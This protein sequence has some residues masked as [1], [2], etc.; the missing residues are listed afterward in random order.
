M[1]LPSYP[2]ACLT[3]GIS[4]S[5][6]GSGIQADI[7][8]FTALS[9]HGASVVVAVAAQSLDNRHDLHLVPTASVC[10]QLD[11]A[12]EDLPVGCVKVGLIPSLDTMR[13]VARW[14][15]EHPHLKVVV[16]PVSA[17][18]RGLPLHSPEQ[19]AVLKDELLP[20]ATVATPNRQEAALLAGLEEVLSREDME[21][22]AKTILSKHGCPTLVTGGGL[23][24]QSLDVLA[25]MDGLRHFAFPTVGRRK[26]HGAGGTLSAA[27]A[28]NLAKGDSVREAVLAGKLYVSAALQ[29][30][31]V[32]P[33]GR[34]VLWHP[35]TVREGVIHGEN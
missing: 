17:D 7:K 31:P 15:R 21:L 22:A 16:D 20:R 27:I 25:A 32:L 3:I 5:S 10:A 18:T 6:G 33:D 29:A 30:A 9:C 19:L 34:A 11:A 14:L 12:V 26:A 8:T 2:T 1:N 13:A 28:V 24:G 23:S 4:D 35:V